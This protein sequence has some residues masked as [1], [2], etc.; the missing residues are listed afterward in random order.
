MICTACHRPVYRPGYSPLV[1]T[2]DDDDPRCY[3]APLIP[4]DH[5][6]SWGDDDCGCRDAEPAG[7]ASGPHT[8]LTDEDV[9]VALGHAE[10]ALAEGGSDEEYQA[11][12][13]TAVTQFGAKGMDRLA[14]H[15]TNLRADP[16]EIMRA[17]TLDPGTYVRIA[18]G[19]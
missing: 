6:G 8:I 15:W 19:E 18:R 16:K 17:E 11:M 1:V 7:M 14:E 13:W 9:I 2:T 5:W 3:S 12:V 10:L 4:C